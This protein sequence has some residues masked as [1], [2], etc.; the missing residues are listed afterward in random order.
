VSRCAGLS[1][2][3]EQE[4]GRNSVVKPTVALPVHVTGKAGLFSPK[5]SHDGIPLQPGSKGKHCGAF[6]ASDVSP[7]LHLRPAADAHGRFDVIVPSG[8]R[9]LRI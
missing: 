5:Q 2:L 7:C 1:Q 6:A 9:A 4:G 8:G 3:A